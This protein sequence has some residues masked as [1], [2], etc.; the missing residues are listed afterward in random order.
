MPAPVCAPAN[1]T[2]V[3]RLISLALAIWGLAV[4]EGSHDGVFAALA[5]G[6]VAALALFASTFAPAS[7]FL[8]RT[9][10]EVDVPPRAMICALAVCAMGVAASAL[11]ARDIAWHF[12]GPLMLALCAAAIDRALRSRVLRSP[13]GSAPVARRASI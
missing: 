5:D 8:D 13:A 4:A 3:R 1:S 9:L 10:R 11:Y 7:Y 2:N 6:E 12:A